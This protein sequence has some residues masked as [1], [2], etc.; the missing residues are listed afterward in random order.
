MKWPLCTPSASLPARFSPPENRLEGSWRNLNSLKSIGYREIS[1]IRSFRL[2][3]RGFREFW[4]IEIW[5]KASQPEFADK[6]ILRFSVTGGRSEKSQKCIV[7]I[8][9]LSVR[10]PAMLL[11]KD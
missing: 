10:N 5:E 3:N 6:H 4:D 9:S 2:Q 11:R 1:Q 8:N 7:G